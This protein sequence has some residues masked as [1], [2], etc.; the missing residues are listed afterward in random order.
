MGLQETIIVSILLVAVIALAGML[1]SSL[2]MVDIVKA[3]R[4]DDFQWV[5][6]IINDELPDIVECDGEEVSTEGKEI[7][8]IRGESM[9]QY[10]I[11]DNCRGI[12]SLFSNEEKLSI[13]GMP[14][15]E[16]SIHDK[17]WAIWE[18]H[19]K[20]RKFI[21]YLPSHEGYDFHAIYKEFKDYISIP[22]AIFV[23]ECEKR[24]EEMHK[25]WKS[26]AGQVLVLSETF[27]CRKNR[28][29]YSI[30]RATSLRGRLEY[31]Y[32]PEEV[33]EEAA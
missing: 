9:R 11:H 32:N 1:L 17:K 5:R 14:I 8:V 10:G 2:N 6:Q 30:H 4:I 27:D 29:H 15:V 13:T 16:F 12:I 21:T 23:Q 18:S 24:M 3:G 22:E 33:V 7:I 31:F 19:R 25:K 20:L 28:N 26:Y